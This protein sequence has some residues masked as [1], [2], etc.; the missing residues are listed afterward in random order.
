MS[1]GPSFTH[2]DAGTESLQKSK[3]ASLPVV[4][5]VGGGFG[6]LSAAQALAGAP[7]QIMLIDRSNHHLFQ[8]LLYQVATAGLSPADVAKPIRSILRYQKNVEVILDEVV[9]ISPTTRTIQTQ[10][11]TISYDYLIVATGARHAY[12]GHK[13]WEAHAPGLKT[14]GDAIDI[15]RRVLLAFE[16][17]EKARDESERRECMTFVVVGGGPTGVEM[18][19]AIAE[20]GNFTLRKDF[21][22]IDPSQARV[23][24]V[25]AGSRLLSSFD[26]SLSDHALKDLQALN[27]EV[28]LGKRLTH[29]DANHVEV[30]GERIGCRTIVWAAGN[31]ASPLAAMLGEVDNQGRLKVNAD[32]SVPGHAEIQAVG[33]TVATVYKS[34]KPVPGVSPAAM[35]AG[36]HAA[37]NIIHM[38]RGQPAKPWEYIDKG[39]MATIGRHAAVCELGPLRFAGLPAWLAW[40]FVHL[41]FLMSFRNRTA[42]FLQWTW[43]YFTYS[44]G[45][46]IISSR[47]GVAQSV[48]ERAGAAGP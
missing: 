36:R 45:A 6:G 44:K 37:K 48:V 31:L 18:A 43:A 42:V 39:S 38:L 8:P 21:R 17:A 33:D 23:I 28:M 35:Q 1:R 16:R 47:D 24:L 13:D 26:Q 11:T 15:R 3:I 25:E 40:A 32:L 9:S 19:G 30:D 7:V 4:V 22:K 14:L 41:F 20:L 27:V 10:E 2:V 34:G 12:F 29:L 5:I 46:R